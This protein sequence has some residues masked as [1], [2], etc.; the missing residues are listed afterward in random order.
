MRNLL[1]IHLESLNYTNYRTNRELFPVLHKWERKSLSF[2]RYFST[3]T[4]TLMVI[5]DMAYGG[6][7]QNEPCDELTAGL[8]RYCYKDS[9]LDELQKGGYKVKV[10]GYPVND[11]G[12][13]IGCNARH[14][15]GFG[16]EMEEMVSYESYLRSLNEV[17][18][19]NEPFAVWAC[20]YISNVSYNHGAGNVEG[21]DG[22][23]RWSTGYE[24]MDCCVKDL[25]DILEK[26][27]L[28]ESTSIIF[29]GDHGDDLFSHGRHRGLMHT[30]EPYEALIHT[31]FWI[32]DSRFEPEDIDL[33]IDTSDI[34]EIIGRLL[35][36]PEQKLEIQDLKLPVRKYSWARNI[37]AAQRVRETSFHKA[38]SITDG[39]FLFLTGNQGMELYHIG[40]DATCQH[41][42]LDY[43]DFNEDILSLNQEAYGRMKFHFP[44]VIDKKALQQIETNFY[45]YRKELM[46]KVNSIYEYAGC[47]NL[48]LEID[49]GNIYYGW[50]ERERRKYRKQQGEARG[51]FDLFRKYLEGKRIVLYGAGNYGKYF[52][53]KMMECAEI[54]A[55]ADRSYEHM[56]KI[57]GYEIQCPDC[58]KYLEFDAV[59]IAIVN[60]KIKQEVKNML[61]QMGISADK[62]Y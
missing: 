25:M 13:V 33:L 55:W 9:F 61:V 26:K 30:I 43:F 35:N 15:I 36:L 62:I 45:E 12:D 37:Y 27:N 54:V 20:N 48:T 22:L 1:L 11:A 56:P 4:S 23:E 17:I 24:Y 58:I 7:L 51:E 47:E 6:I 39:R 52:Y 40:M 41:N 49:F 42:L 2:S 3:A 59:F 28:L 16:V 50:E 31:P 32:Y 38:Y 5:S 19:G 46:A 21:Q 8:T 10:V 53:E 34:R 29:Y 18:N 44:S 60:N 14:F 57:F